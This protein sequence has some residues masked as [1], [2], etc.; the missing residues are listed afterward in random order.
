MASCPFSTAAPARISESTGWQQRAVRVQKRG[1]CAHLFTHVP[2]TAN[3]S[4]V[5]LVVEPTQN[6]LQSAVR[7]HEPTLGVE[8]V[9]TLRGG[10]SL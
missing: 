7:R 1:C 4:S 10:R 6:A 9:H 5:P 2:A 8:I 3:L